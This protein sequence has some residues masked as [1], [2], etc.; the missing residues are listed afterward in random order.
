MNIK[1]LIIFLLFVLCI[2]CGK[3]IDVFSK[4]LDTEYRTDVKS[5][6]NHDN[7]ILIEGK[8]YLYKVVQKD[9]N[10]ILNFDLILKT[11][12]GNYSNGTKIKYKHY[13]NDEFLTEEEKSLYLDSIKFYKWDITSAHENKEEFY[14]HP[15]RSYTLKKLEITPFPQLKLPPIEGDYSYSVNN[16]IA[17]YGEYNMNRVY[18][19]YHIKDIIYNVDSSFVVTINASSNWGKEKTDEKI[20]IANFEFDSK[21][22]FTEMSYLFNDSTS[23]VFKMDK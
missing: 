9:K 12:P 5:K 16:I 8:E 11:I 18:S 22:G 15:P 17:G 19:E 6:F 3:I 13:Y 2:S 23:I 1:L 20:C 14:I 10:R 21:L 7:K 4:D